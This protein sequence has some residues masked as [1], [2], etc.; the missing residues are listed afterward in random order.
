[1]H[2]FFFFFLE[3]RKSLT[4][5]G[6]TFPLLDAAMA[7][8]LMSEWK[9]MKGERRCED[10]NDEAPQ[11]K[12]MKLFPGSAYTKRTLNAQRISTKK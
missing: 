5:V 1:M 8:S 6:C 4:L 11:P 10:A 3:N 2:Y 9:L 7:S 12:P